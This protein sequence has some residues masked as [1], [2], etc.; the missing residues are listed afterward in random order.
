MTCEDRNIFLRYFKETEEDVLE[1]KNYDELKFSDDFMFCKI[2]QNNPELC[3]ELLELVLDKEI[4]ELV[5][6]GKQYPIEIT[7]DG[8]GVRFDVYAK[9]DRSVIYDVEMQNASKESLPKRARYNQALI[10]L[11]QLERGAK[12]EELGTSFVIFICNFDLVPDAGRHKY[13][14][15]NLCAEDPEIALEDGT[16]K[17]FLCSTGTKNDIS[18][19]LAKFLSYVAGNAPEDDLSRRLEEALVQA[20]DNPLWRKEYMDLRDY[21]DEAREEGREEGRAE[22]QESGEG[23]MGRLSK[24]L[25]REGRID[26]ICRAADDAEYRKQLYEEFAIE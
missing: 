10:D 7:A 26:D 17:L 15:L 21:I 23:K 19:E 11:E 9:D 8:R 18:S 13:T 22:G 1:K 2:M 4:G 3:R 24:A 12:F 16:A 20:R 14:F 6:L 25:A 5:T